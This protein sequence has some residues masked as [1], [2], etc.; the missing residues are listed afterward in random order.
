MPQSGYNYMKA[1]LSTCGEILYNSQAFGKL[2]LTKASEREILYLRKH[3]I[4]YVS[5]F[6]NV[7]PRTTAKEHVVS[8]LIES[9]EDTLSATKKAEEEGMNRVPL[10]WE[11]ILQSK[12]VQK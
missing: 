4:G 7:M 1:L 6:L 11:I 8:A 3:E 12:V 2:D 10:K 9:G 5:Q